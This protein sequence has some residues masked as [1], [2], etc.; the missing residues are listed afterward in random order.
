V[1]AVGLN[2]RFRVKGNALTVEKQR[3]TVQRQNLESR[4][5]ALF[6][7]P[8]FSRRWNGAPIE[9]ASGIDLKSYL[10]RIEVLAQIVIQLSLQSQLEEPHTDRT[11]AA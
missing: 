10:D 4:A 1:R 8:L 7:L 6:M 3:C 11:Q 2:R 5:F 9:A